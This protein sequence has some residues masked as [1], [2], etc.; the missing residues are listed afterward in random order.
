MTV[1]DRLAV[2]EFKVDVMCQKL[3]ILVAA[4][5]EEDAPQHDLDGN[6][7]PR[8]RPEHQSL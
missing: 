7:I 3:E 6:P 5:A 8:D 2:L 4:L 1:E